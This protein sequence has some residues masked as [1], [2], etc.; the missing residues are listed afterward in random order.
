VIS[1]SHAPITVRLRGLLGTL[2]PSLARVARV[3]LDDPTSVAGLSIADLAAAADTSVASVVRLYHKLDMAGYPQLRL[4]LA[5]EAGRNDQ[6][7]LP[8]TS[9]IDPDDSLSDVIQKIAFADARAV[10]ETAASVSVDILDA[11]VGRIV[12]AEKVAVFGVGASAT[13]AADLQQKLHRIGCIVYAWGDAHL[14]MTGVALLSPADVAIGISYG[15]A[16]PDT[17]DP[18][19]LAKANGAATIAIT[20]S[21]DSP[22]AAEA[23]HVLL[24]AARETTFR[25]GA[26][27]SRIAQLVMNDFIFV[28]VAQ[29]RFDASQKAI[30]LTAAAL[31]SRRRAKR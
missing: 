15:G 24:T 4:A 11:V 21:P 30:A 16:T 12:A 31:E 25:S 27:A 26:T 22:L 7:K 6:I 28:A 19:M 5:R 8:R 17:I 23:D 29:R 9:D 2:Q 10:E 18:L 14:A 20:N 3:I 13:V 1:E